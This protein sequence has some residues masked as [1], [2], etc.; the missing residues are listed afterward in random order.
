MFSL[1]ASQSHLVVE[2]VSV[3][4][5]SLDRSML[6]RLFIDVM[7]LGVVVPAEMH[8]RAAIRSKK[9]RD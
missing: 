5:A 1:E 8:L 4:L 9:R 7:L 6:G 2:F 3:Q